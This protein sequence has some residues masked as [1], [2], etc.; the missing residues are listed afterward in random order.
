MAYC[1]L[2]VFQ[3]NLRTASRWDSSA[4]CSAVREVFLAA[5]LYRSED[6]PGLHMLRRSF[7]SHALAQRT[8]IE[9]VRELGGWSDLA[10]VQPY[11][12]STEHLKREAVERLRFGDVEA[13]TIT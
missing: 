10:V 6:R 9:T 4:L 7:A 11:V 12:A 1:Q 3:R 2:S 13:D 5:G 8:D